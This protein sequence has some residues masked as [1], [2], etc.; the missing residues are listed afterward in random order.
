MN[1][2]ITFG[3]I[4]QMYVCMYVYLVITTETANLCMYVV[5]MYVCMSPVDLV[6]FFSDSKAKIQRS[7]NISA[8]V[9][10]L[11][12]FVILVLHTYIHTYIHS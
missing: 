12:C 5:C 2:Y 7:R 4:G 3:H 8:L 9:V 11:H 1:V 6:F 10:E